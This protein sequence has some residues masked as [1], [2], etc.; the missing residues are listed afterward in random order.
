M[1]SQYVYLLWYDLVYEEGMELVGAYTVKSELVT[2]VKNS[3][4]QSEDEL[5]VQTVKENRKLGPKRPFEE[6]V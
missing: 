3:A 6:F 2:W 1:R 5:Y 4:W